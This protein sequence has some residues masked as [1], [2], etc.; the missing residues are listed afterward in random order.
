MVRGDAARCYDCLPQEAVM[1]TV[2]R[3][4]PHEFYH[5]LS[6]TAVAPLTDG[7]GTATVEGV[8]VQGWKTAEEDAP[9]VGVLL[10]RRVKLQTVSGKCVQ[11]GTL[12]GIPKGW[13]MYEEPIPPSESVMRGDE[14]RTVL[15]QHLQKH[16]VVIEGIYSQ[17]VGITQGSA[18]A[19]LLCD[20][21][22]ETVDHSLSNIL[23]QHEGRRCFYDEW[24]MSWWLR[25]LLWRLL[26]VMRRCAMDGLRWDFLPR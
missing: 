18:V 1:N 16:L 6:F 13:I 4:L 11:N 7:R 10:H 5:T 26:D 9:S 8:G 19:M 25:S 23:S 12:P 3:L 15:G 24:M 2:R 21:L 17:G 14:M 20:I 22:L